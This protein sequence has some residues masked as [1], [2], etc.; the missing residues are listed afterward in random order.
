MKNVLSASL[1]I[2]L[3]NTANA[4]ST[5]NAE[6]VAN[7]NIMQEASNT[8]IKLKAFLDQNQEDDVFFIARVGIN[9]MKHGVKYTHSAFVVRNGDSYDVIHLLNECDTGD[10]SIYSQG[11]MNFYLDSLHNMNTVVIAPTADL[12]V[13][14]KQILTTKEALKLHNPHY[15]MI[16]YPY[17]TQYQN[18]NQWVL[19]TTVMALNANV[20]N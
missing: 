15:S 13:R 4:G 1:A 16:A 17:A 12:Q 11:L 8:A 2:L 19:E 20:T 10:S 9:A 14:L 5:C 3:A 6:F 7:S 18:S